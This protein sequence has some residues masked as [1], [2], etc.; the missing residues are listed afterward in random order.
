M[1]TKEH[2]RPTASSPIIIYEYISSDSSVSSRDSSPVV[3]GAAPIV[4]LLESWV[5]PQIIT[6][7]VSPTA[8]KDIPEETLDAQAGPTNRATGDIEQ[9]MIPMLNGMLSKEE[10]N[11][12]RCI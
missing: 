9:L 7:P 4:S 11:V 2:R 8:D 1:P 10:T 3:S 5:Y 6:V 12:N